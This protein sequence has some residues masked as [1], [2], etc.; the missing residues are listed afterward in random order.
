[1]RFRQWIFDIRWAQPASYSQH[2]PVV[3]LFM[4]LFPLPSLFN[5]IKS[6]INGI[7][8]IVRW[9]NRTPTFASDVLCRWDFEISNETKWT[10]FCDR[11]NESFFYALSFTHTIASFIT[12]SLLFPVIF[13]HP[14]LY[15]SACASIR[16]CI[17]LLVYPCACASIRLCIHA[18]V[19][20]S[21]CAFHPLVHSYASLFGCLCIRVLDLLH[22][23]VIF[24]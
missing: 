5:S 17:H 23:P 16:L 7:I 19:Y 13:S 2:G 10:E 4:S 15:P 3:C 12:H 1:M 20:P 11:C 14:S 6:F 22:P 21:A 9:Y 8:W 18:C 24:A